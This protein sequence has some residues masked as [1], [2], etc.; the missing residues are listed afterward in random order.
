MKGQ[1][2]AE[3]GRE[4]HDTETLRDWLIERHAGPERT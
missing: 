1:Q 3:T 2:A 4:R